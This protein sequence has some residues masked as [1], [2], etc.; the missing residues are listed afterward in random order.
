MLLG[1]IKALARTPLRAARATRRFGYCVTKFAQALGVKIKPLAPVPAPP[2]DSARSADPV[3]AILAMPE[4]QDT[5]RWFAENPAAQRSLVSPDTQALLFTLVRNLK[6]A[7]VF[8][9]GSYRCGSSEAICRALCE[10]GMGTLH[11]TD[12][13]GGGVVPA[14][15]LKWPEAMRRHV[16]FHVLDSMAFYMLMT[17]IRTCAGLIF[18]DGNHE[19]EFALFDLQA[20]ARHL[21]PGGFVLL[22]NVSQPGP[23]FAA[24]DFMRANSDWREC[25]NSLSRYRSSHPFDRN[26]TAIHNTDLLVLRA[27]PHIT[28][29][30]RPR[31][32]GQQLFASRTV[33]GMRL[34]LRE[35]ATSGTLTAQCVLRGFGRTP[36]EVVGETNL[37]LCNAEQN[38]EI[39]FF[40][41]IALD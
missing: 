16:H 38:V 21:V 2:P 14:I 12:P 7:N 4:F 39:R 17:S 19:Y 11:T 6:P 1:L 3:A 23:F 41:P 30:A 15:L 33:S 26:R 36:V 8:E 35:R 25:G 18:I 37:A 32:V 27:P 31:T 24:M 9:I 10:N 29:A 34:V 40:P 20:A 13:F 28:I 22:D 5:V